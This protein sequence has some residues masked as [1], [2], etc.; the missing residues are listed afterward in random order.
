MTTVSRTLGKV[1]MLWCSKPCSGGETGRKACLIA[2]SL[3]TYIH[4]S[5]DFTVVFVVIGVHLS[6][7]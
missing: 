5:E 2:R 4:G 7:I 6:E 1:V 3:P